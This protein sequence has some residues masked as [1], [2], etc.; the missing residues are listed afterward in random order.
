MIYKT[1][2][3]PVLDQLIDPEWRHDL[4]HK[5]IHLLEN[6]PLGLKILNLLNDRLNRFSHRKLHIKLGGVYLDNPVIIAAG[7]DKTG[8]TV[9]GL[10]E[11][12]FGAVEIGSVPTYPQPGN[13]K[14][15]LFKLEKGVYLNRMGFN[16]P[17]LDVVEKNLQRY[18]K[19]KIPIGINAGI[20]KHI[21]PS[22]APTSYAYV[23][24]RL[25][26]F[27]SYFVI[28]VSSPNTPGLR[29]LQ[30][31]KPLIN[32]VQAVQ[33]AIKSAGPKKPLYIKIAPDLTKG[34]IDDVIEVVIHNKVTGIIATNTSSHPKIK[35]KYGILWENEMGG[36]SGKD[37]EFRQKSSK[38]IAYIYQKAGKKLEVIGV[39][40]VDNFET[41]LEKIQAG[42]K[43]IQLLTGLRS[44]GP[45]V[46]GSI[47]RGLV[48]YMDEHR[49]KH[50]SD[51][52]GIEANKYK[53]ISK[54]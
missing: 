15:R 26:R 4:T 50:I 38:I 8:S 54:I 20:N 40:G 6:S 16:S 32:I 30:D 1:F 14:P 45:G 27:A 43:A 41:A 47:N 33:K 28:N 2:I 51:L 12:G 23:V 9:K 52:V 11:L 3:S 22:E 37:E 7:W 5:F 46:A 10:Y 25:Y 17:G 44:E 21:S 42:A 36:V 35:S 34:A 18:V 53:L 13:P 19:S 39:G 31:K 49:I 48:K 24:K 29:K